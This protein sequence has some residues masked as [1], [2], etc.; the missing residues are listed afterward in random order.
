LGPACG[1]RKKEEGRRKKEELEIKKCHSEA[2]TFL[3]GGYFHT[4]DYL[5]VITEAAHAS[6]KLKSC[7]YDSATR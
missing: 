4:F 5:T 3:R 2:G 6:Q 1:R 7:R